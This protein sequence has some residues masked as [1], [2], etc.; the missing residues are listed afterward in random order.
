MAMKTNFS[1]EL[2][3]NIYFNGKLVKEFKAEFPMKNGLKRNKFIGGGV[4]VLAQQQVNRRKG[5]G[6]LK[7]STCC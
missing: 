1:N 3:G 5:F 7:R 6:C 4:L 2:L